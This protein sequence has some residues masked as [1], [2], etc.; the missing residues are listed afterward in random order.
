MLRK[1][2]WFFIFILSI[3]IISLLLYKMNQINVKNDQDAE[4]IIDQQIQTL[5]GI[6]AELYQTTSPISQSYGNTFTDDQFNTKDD[7]KFLSDQVSLVLDT[8]NKDNVG[9]F[10]VYR[11]IMNETAEYYE[12]YQ[13]RTE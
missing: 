3:I 8:I 7:R 2:K 4:I 11:K 6:K 13:K 1:Y 9:A 12:N 5:Q 10:K